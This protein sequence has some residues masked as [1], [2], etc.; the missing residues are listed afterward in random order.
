MLFPA[1]RKMKHTEGSFLLEKDFC[2]FF[3]YKKNPE[4]FRIVSDFSARYEKEINEKCYPVADYYGKRTPSV[5]MTFDKALTGEEYKIK[6]NKKGVFITYGEPVGAFRA[7][8]T[9]MQLIR[10][11]GKKLPFIDIHDFPDIKRRGFMLDISRA[12][13]PKLKEILRIIDVL[14]ELKYNELQLYLENHAFEYSAYPEYSKDIEGLTPFEVMKIV[15]YCNERYIDVVPNQNSF[16]HMYSW[17]QK[18]E[19]RELELSP[20]DFSVNPLDPRSIDLLN[21]IYDSLLPCF[22]SDFFNVGCDE[23]GELENSE[24]VKEAREKY[25]VAAVYVNHLLKL[26]E[27]LCQRGKRMLFWADIIFNHPDKISELPKDMIPLVWGYEAETDFDSPGKTLKKTGL[28]FYFCPGTA[29]WAAVLGDNEKARQ[30]IYNA[31]KFCKKHGGTGVL[32]TDWGDAGHCQPFIVSYMAVAFCAGVCWNLRG[33]ED[34]TIA[35]NFVD[36][37][38]FEMRKGSFCDILFRASCVLPKNGNC[39]DAFLSLLQNFDDYSTCRKT[40]HSRLAE[41][42]KDFCFLK[43]ESRSLIMGCKE[44]SRYIDEFCCAVDVFILLIDLWALKYENMEKGKIRNF[45]VRIN[46]I[47]RRAKEIKVFYTRIWVEINHAS[48][49]NVFWDVVENYIKKIRDFY[50]EKNKT[51]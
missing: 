40:E 22:T 4:I 47:E 18:P 46:E 27:M 10:E 43:E 25:G 26:H 8:T 45:N 16:G 42:K 30:N 38:V 1:P 12:R 5:S 39:T 28:D 34:F 2:L 37:F 9:F 21:N 20:G 33:N 51:F 41:A 13:V 17:V 50:A 48:G 3:E 24:K 35:E 49:V 11:N 15:E 23:V 44:A 31:A 36:T 29:S 6:I 19:L 14:A 32:L 7:A